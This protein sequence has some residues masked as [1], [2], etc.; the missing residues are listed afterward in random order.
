MSLDFVAFCRSVGIL[1][2]SLPP[3]GRWKRYPTEDHP[4]K[5][6]GAVKFMGDRGVVQNHATMQDVAIW[7]TDT[8]A[9]VID[10]AFIRR[11]AKRER[12]RI[13]AGRKEAAQK[14]QAMLKAA[15]LSTH[16][17]LA[18]KG[19][20]EMQGLVS[21][22]RLLVPM[23]VDTRVVGL[24]VIAED[25]SKKFLHGQQ[26]GGATYAIGKG[27]K[28]WC[29][30]YATGLSVHAAAHA[31]RIKAMVVVT[32]SAHNL[33]DLARDGFVIADNDVSGTGE[34][35]AKA[36]GLPY[37]LSERCPEDFNDYMR[38]V[39]LFGASQAVKRLVMTKRLTSSGAAL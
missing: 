15:S 12:E 27:I 35:A 19:F 22:G 18:A 30:G 20:P 39:G 38:R 25:G 32:F 4:R 13:A 5:R 7:H 11:E 21:E 17:Y 29:E 1:I 37:W 3:I 36:T 23:H 28:L 24:Q 16:P 33:R 14:A 10:R 2:D 9:V 34:A 31:A 6:N 26:S 8:P